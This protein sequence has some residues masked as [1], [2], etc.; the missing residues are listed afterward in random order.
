ML[1][2]NVTMNKKSKL[3]PYSIQEETSE[4][5]LSFPDNPE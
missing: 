2:I 1:I 3:N 4:I 5:Q